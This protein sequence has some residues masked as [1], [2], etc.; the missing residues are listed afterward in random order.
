MEPLGG[1]GAKTKDQDFF[2]GLPVAQTF[3]NDGGKFRMLRIMAFV[4]QLKQDVEVA[5]GILGLAKDC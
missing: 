2:T 4:H 5:A 3:I 1:V